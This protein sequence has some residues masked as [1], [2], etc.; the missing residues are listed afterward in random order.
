MSTTAPPFDRDLENGPSVLPN[1]DS[2]M[3]NGTEDDAGIGSAISSSNSSI[4][5]EEVEADTGTE[6]GPLHPC[7]P[8]LN[9]H[10]PV[11]SAEYTTTR[12]IRIRR[13]WLLEGDA[14]P[15]YSNLYPEILMDAG[16]SEQ[17]F[18]DIIRNINMR[19]KEAFDPLSWRNVLDSVVGAA[20]GWLW[21]D[22]GVTGIKSKLAKVEEWV[23]EWNR[24]KE[25]NFQ[26]GQGVFAPQLISLRQT[27]YM[28][29]CT[30]SLHRRL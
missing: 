23:E 16:L 13:D 28:S 3:S 4:M 7:Y 24:R 21:D 25:A 1:R 2:H 18:R 9:P 15:A 27:G 22:L 14:A 30:L 11:E 17:E 10:V 12:I 19:L 6:W 29:V 5:G 26:T 8:H 20:T